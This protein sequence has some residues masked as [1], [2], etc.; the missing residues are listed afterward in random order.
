MNL[1]GHDIG[2]PLQSGATLAVGDDGF[3]LKAG[4]ADIW[5]EADQFHFACA[6]VEG[7][8]EVQVRV[9][10]LEEGHAYTKAGL[11][12][13]ESLDPSSAHFFHLVFPDNRLRN[14]NSGGFE[15]QYRL[16]TG[17]PSVAI[18]PP[19][20]SL[21][22]PEF[23]VDYPDVWLRIARKGAW[24]E[25][26]SSRDGDAWALF[27]RHEQGLPPRVLVGLA[28]TSHDESRRIHARFREF[29][30]RT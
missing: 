27:A 10:F 7:D 13:R 25:A 18:Y 1:K 8:F 2:Q 3:D 28:L 4:G 16:R 12:V 20:K 14:N 21:E 9:E 24:F 26:S 11:M 15:S 22:P 6:P 30:V 5:D 23:P 29:V 17:A 19:G